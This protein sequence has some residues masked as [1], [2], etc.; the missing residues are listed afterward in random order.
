MKSCKLIQPL[1][2]TLSYQVF[3]TFFNLE[4]ISRTSGQPHPSPHPKGPKKGLS[5]LQNSIN[6]RSSDNLNI[7][8]LL[9]S[10]A[11]WSWIVRKV[12]GDQSSTRAAHLVSE[13]QGHHSAGQL[14]Q[15]ADPKDVHEL[16]EN[17][18]NRTNPNY[19]FN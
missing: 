4:F 7:L 17:K 18:C 10:T 5:C 15:Q 11:A 8:Y 14:D 19:S 13:D 9:R 16:Q 1:L 12:L 3:S 6:Q 2:H